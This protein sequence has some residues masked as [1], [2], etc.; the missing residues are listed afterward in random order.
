MGTGGR[1]VNATCLWLATGRKI[2]GGEYVLR[3]VMTWGSGAGLAFG[4][5]GEVEAGLI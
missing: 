5:M 1:G 2:N 4:R 3:N